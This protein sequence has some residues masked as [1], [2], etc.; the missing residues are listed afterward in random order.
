MPE[1]VNKGNCRAMGINKVGTASS[2][3]P[4]LKAMARKILPARFLGT[5]KRSMDRISKWQRVRHVARFRRQMAAIPPGVNTTVPLLHYTVRTNSGLLVY[6]LYRDIFIEQIYYFEAQRPDPLI[7]DL[8]SHIG[9]SILYFKHL[10]PQA[11]IIGFEPDP[12]ILPFLKENIAQN[13]LTAVQLVPAALA[14]REMALTLYS[15]NESGSSLIEHLP[16]AASRKQHE[17][18]GVRLRDYLTEPVDFMKMNIEGAEWEVLA[19]SEDRLH[20]VREMVIEYHH[21]P[22][23]PRTL[24]NILELLHRHHFEYM[25]SDFGLDSYGPPPPVRLHPRARYYRLIHAVQ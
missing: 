15:D 5:L 22:D 4:F 16:K 11:R 13:S 18:S 21:L 9:I 1:L 14:V 24:H 6:D 12:L 19:D 10:Y 25:V 20:Q 23:L 17:I 8:G 3:S 2:T 7:L